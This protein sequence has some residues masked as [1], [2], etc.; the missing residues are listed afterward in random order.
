MS[1]CP[2]VR[3]RL[4]SYAVEELS[5]VQRRAVREHL[6]LCGA[7]REAAA[8]ADPTLLFAKTVPVE[9]VSGADMARILEGVRVGVALKQAERRLAKHRRPA[10]RTAAVAAAAAVAFF[11][12]ALPGGLSRRA[13]APAARAAAGKSVT[14]GFAKASVTAPADAAGGATVYEISPGSG[15]DNPRVVWIVDRSLDI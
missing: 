4:A 15:P 8:A 13:S 9:D 6:A 3:A 14:P 10:R 5:S 11:T 2:D 7:C 12:L 1:S